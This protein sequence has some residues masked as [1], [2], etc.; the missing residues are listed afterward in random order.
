MKKVPVSVDYSKDE[1]RANAM[2]HAVGFVVALA[3]LP[4]LIYHGG[5]NATDVGLL[6]IWIYAFSL[7]AMLGSSRAY[8]S[9]KEPGTK[10]LMK[11][12]DHICIYFLIAGSY[13]AFILNRMY[14][15]EALWY[16]AALWGM[17]MVGI[18][19]KARYVHRFKFF[20]TLIYLLMAYILMLDPRL[21]S[22]AASETCN[23]LILVGAAIYTSGV[24]FYLW[25]SRK[26]THAIWHVLV[27]FASGCHFAAFLHEFSLKV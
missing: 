19:F 18:W 27:L 7:L 9:V 17:A 2:T 20:S 23:N 4:F 21:F 16:L 10:L 12:F 25:K 24:V 26:W 5:Q 3:A 14:F 1:E 22:Q 15:E 8:H 13:T 6:G 11:K